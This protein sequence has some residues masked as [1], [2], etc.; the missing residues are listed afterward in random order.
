MN[1]IVQKFG[2][3]SL[4][5]DDL[6]RAA[7]AQVKR[8][9]NAGQT[10]VVVV[11]ALGRQGDPY[12]TDTLIQLMKGI[13]NRPSSRSLDLIMSCGETIAAALF[14]EELAA[15]GLVAVALTGWQSGIYTDERHGEAFVERID[16]ARLLA[17]IQAGKIPVVTGF[18][19]LSQAGE[20]TTLG[21][22]GSDTTAAA[23]GVALEASWI[24]IFTDVNG[25][26]TADPS[27]VPDAGTIEALTYQEVVELAHLGAKVIHPRAVEIAMDKGIPLKVLSV[28]ESYGGTVIGGRGRKHIKESAA[29]GDRVVAG[30]AH[31]AQRAK[32]QIDG[33]EDFN[34]SGMALKVFRRL[35]DSDV[36]VDL[37]YLSPDRVGFIVDAAKAATTQQ[38]LDRLGLQSR[39]D[40]GY[41]KVSV[42]GAGMHGVPGVMARVVACLEAIEVPILQTTD[43][44]ANISCLIREEHLAPAVSA[45][46][47]E[48]NLS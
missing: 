46:H 2:G 23:L 15:G 41:A 33:C 21:R 1:V 28:N 19:G 45:L 29:I 32:V 25:V 4:I 18:Q 17:E 42:V 10:P 11:S 39:V 22:G 31:M 7:A 38:V 36:S 34:A 3:R 24:E 5:N 27:I 13:N 9:L 47:K 8:A 37:I 48:F 14:A 44:H 6:R 26:K 30:I 20:V 12:A 40:L 16:T 43:S 35:A